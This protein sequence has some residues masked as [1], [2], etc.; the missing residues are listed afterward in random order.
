MFVLLV[1]TNSH[2]NQYRN[3]IHW[4]ILTWISVKKMNLTD[5]FDIF[6]G[7]YENHMEKS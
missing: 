6:N 7:A 3:Y 4:M 2:D 5:H 1:T